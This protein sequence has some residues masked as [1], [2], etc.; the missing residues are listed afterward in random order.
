M[1]LNEYEQNALLFNVKFKTA[2]SDAGTMAYRG[3]LVL[4]EGEVA[5]DQGRRKP[6]VSIVRHAVLLEKDG[7]LVMSVGFIDDL[8]MLKDFVEKYSPD[9]APDMSAMFYVVNI[10][11]PMQVKIDGIN[12]LLLPLTD[13]IAWNEMTEELGL[14]KSDFKGQSPADKVVTAYNELKSY[15]PKYPEVASFDEALSKIV[16]LKRES[17]G[18]I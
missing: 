13:G 3:E 15:T 16:D 17:R 14:E 4:I 1:A 7:K 8:A 9:F 5:D 18:P 6:P 10:A 2:A 12:F 11:E